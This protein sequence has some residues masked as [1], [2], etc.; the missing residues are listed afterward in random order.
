MNHKSKLMA[1]ASY[2]APSIARA[3]LEADPHRFDG[4]HKAASAVKLNQNVCVGLGCVSRK[5]PEG[6]A[7]KVEFFRSRISDGKIPKESIP[8]LLRDYPELR[9]GNSK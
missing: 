3:M 5:T 8:A 9:K 7:K 1:I 6:R 4:A 2:G